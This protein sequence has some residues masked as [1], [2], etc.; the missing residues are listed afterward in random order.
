[1]HSQDTINQFIE[2]RSRD[3]PYADIATQLNI[4]RHTAMRWGQKYKPRIDA[5]IATEADALRHKYFGSRQTEIEVLSKRLAR[6]EAELDQRN[7]QYMHTRELADLMRATRTRLDK[8]CAE[9]TLPQEASADDIPL[10]STAHPPK[11]Q[12]KCDRNPVA[13]S[14]FPNK[15]ANL[16]PHGC[17]L[18]NP[19]HTP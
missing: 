18:E 1:M 14:D 16:P 17:I 12:P 9:P 6:F 2:L 15:S 5:W 4:N 3:V 11:M 13:N 19:A 8:L 7:P 10:S